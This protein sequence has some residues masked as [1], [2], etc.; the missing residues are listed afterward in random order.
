MPAFQTPGHVSLRLRLAAGEVRIETADMAET[1]LELEAVHDHE[2][3]R[4]AIAEA[5]VGVR[6]RGDGH[7]VYVEVPKRWGIHFGRSR[8]VRIT[9]RCPHGTDLDLASAS[10]DLAVEGRLGAVIV[11]SASGDTDLGRVDGRL[12]VTSA[13]GDVQVESVG[14]EL[15]LTSASGDVRVGRAEGDI[16]SITVSGDQLFEAV[17]GGEIRLQ[18]VSGDIRIGIV[19]GTKLWIDATSVSGEMHSE[20]DV[21]SEPPAAEGELAQLRAKTVSGDIA[22]VRAERMPA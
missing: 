18:A 19:P 6:A 10:A 5:S 2:S 16:S 11:K 3:S 13:S 17:A 12:A 20:L 21:G 1:E 14:G 22:I 15:A 7:E 4:E 9:V 8:E